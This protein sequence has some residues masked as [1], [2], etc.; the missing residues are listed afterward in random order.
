MLGSKKRELVPL[1]L[2]FMVEVISRIRLGGTS[3]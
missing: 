1:R 3:L 2:L